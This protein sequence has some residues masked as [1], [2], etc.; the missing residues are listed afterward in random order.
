MKVFWK[1]S[2]L[3]SFSPQPGEGAPSLIQVP[4]PGALLLP[5]APPEMREW[6]WNRNPLEPGMKES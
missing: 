2:K 4:D 5:S 1:N 6:G 3:G